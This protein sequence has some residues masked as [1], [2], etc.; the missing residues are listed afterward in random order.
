MDAEIVRALAE[1]YA[2]GIIL[3]CEWP[4]ARDNALRKLA[5][6]ISRE[7]DADGERRKPY[8]LATLIAEAVRQSRFSAWLEMRNEDKKRTARAETQG[9]SQNHP[10]YSMANTKMQ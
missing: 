8:Y 2:G 7:G 4:E 6:I 9:N 1:K 10:H 5:W 3:D